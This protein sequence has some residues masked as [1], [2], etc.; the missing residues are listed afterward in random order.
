V[1]QWSRYTEACEYGATGGIAGFFVS[2]WSERYNG[3][4]MRA[5]GR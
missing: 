4:E 3:D 2:R 1:V 5:Q